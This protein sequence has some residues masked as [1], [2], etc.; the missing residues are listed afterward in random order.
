MKKDYFSLVSAFIVALL[1]CCQL[2]VQAQSCDSLQATTR[3]AYSS[4]GTPLP[5]GILN[6]NSIRP[7]PDG[8]AMI[9]SINIP[10]DKYTGVAGI[11]VPVT[12]IEVGENSVPVALSYQASGIKVQDVASTI[13]LGW[14]LSAGGR[15][16]RAVYGWPDDL[17][18]PVSRAQLLDDASWTVATFRDRLDRCVDTQPDLFY[19]DYPGGGGMFVFDEYGIPS[20]IPGQNLRIEY[21]DRQFV[22]TDINGTEYRF[23]ASEQTNYR[24]GSESDLS[25]K[26]GSFVSTWFL[27]SIRYADGAL[28]TFNYMEASDYCYVN[29]Q[30]FSS[31]DCHH[32]DEDPEIFLP[33]YSSTNDDYIA[34]FTIEIQRPKY[35]SSIRY[36]DRI[37]D[38]SYVSGRQDVPGMLKLSQITTSHA[39]RNIRSYRLAYG[40]FVNKG[41]KLLSLDDVSIEKD[42]R[43]I[44]SFQYHEQINLPARDTCFVKRENVFEAFNY[45]GYTDHWGYY[46]GTKPDSV[47]YKLYNIAKGLF[48]S[49]YKEPS[50]SHAQANTLR[51]ITYGTGGGTKQFE[52]ELHRGVDPSTGV[53]QAAGGLRIRKIVEKAD[54]SAAPSIRSYTY[55]G[56]IVYADTLNYCSGMD[57]NLRI[58]SDSRTEQTGRVFCS[59]KCSNDLTDMN[60]CAVV[61]SAVTEHFPSGARTIYNYVPYDEMPDESPALY[62]VGDRVEY[63]GLDTICMT[64]KTTRHW[65]RRL[66]QRRMDYDANGEMVGSVDYEYARIGRPLKVWSIDYFST[67]TMYKASSDKYIPSYYLSKYYWESQPA[68]LSKV[69]IHKGRHVLASTT[70]YE[71]DETT[72]LPTR[73]VRTDSLGV[74][75]EIEMRYPGNFTLTGVAADHMAQ[76]LAV[77]QERHVLSPFVETVTRRNGRIVDAALNRYT[78]MNDWPMLLERKQLFCEPNAHLTA[79]EHARIDANGQFVSSEEYE[80]V[81]KA[82]GY[83]FDNTLLS[84]S[85]KGGRKSCV[86][87][88]YRNTLPIAVV[89]NA[90]YGHQVVYSGTSEETLHYSAGKNYLSL[91]QS[92][93]VDF[94]VAISP[95][96][97]VGQ[98]L[99]VRIEGRDISTNGLFLQGYYQ[100]VDN[101]IRFTADLRE[102]SY[103][104]Y[105]RWTDAGLAV[106]YPDA[107]TRIRVNDYMP[108]VA[109]VRGYVFHTSFEEEVN[110]P[111]IAPELTPCIFIDNAKSGIRVRRTP[112]EVRLPGQSSNPRDSLELTWWEYHT[113]ATDPQWQMVRRIVPPGNVPMTVVIAA[114]DSVYIDE[115][116]V[117]P[118]DALMTTFTYLPGIGKTSQTD[119]SGVT[120]RYRYDQAGRLTEVLDT[121]GQTVK[122]YTYVGTNQI[123]EETISGSGALQ[124]R[125][126]NLD[127]FGRE[128]IVSE[129]GATP[130]RKDLVQL[131]AYDVMGRADSVVYM[132]YV[133]KGI[134]SNPA[135]DQ[136]AFYRSLLG[137]SMP[138]HAYASMRYDT[139]P[140]GALLASCEPRT[141]ELDEF[142]Y[143]TAFS[144]GFNSNS[145]AVRRYELQTDSVIRWAGYYPAD[146][147]R[148]IE[149]RKARTVSG[150]ESLFR[151]YYDGSDRLV[152]RETM[153]TD[154]H[155]ERTYQVYDDF[156][157]LCYVIPDPGNALFVEN[158]SRTASELN[159]FCYSTFYDRYGRIVRQ[160]KP[161]AGWEEMLY[162]ARDRQ[163]MSRRAGMQKDSTW[164][165][166]RYDAL[167]RPVLTAVHKGGD[168]QTHRTALDAGAVY[169]PALKSAND[170]LTEYHYDDYDWQRDAAHVFAPYTYTRTMNSGGRRVRKT[171]STEQKSCVR[172][173][174]TGRIVKVL[175]VTD[176]VRLATTRFYDVAGRLTQTVSDQYPRQIGTERVI[177]HLNAAGNV[178]AVY[179]EQQGGGDFDATGY[180]KEMEY[181]HC[182][183]LTKVTFLTFID[184]KGAKIRPPAGYMNGWDVLNDKVVLAAY[185]YDELGRI[186]T[187]AIHNGLETSAYS[188][189]LTRPT[190][191]SSP[192]FSYTLAYDKPTT[193]LATSRFDGLLSEVTWSR[194][195]DAPK[196]YVFDYDNFGQLRKARFAENRAGVWT[197]RH[198]FDESADYGPCGTITC[199]GRTVSDGRLAEIEQYYDGFRMTGVE[200]GGQS[201]DDYAYDADGNLT[202]NDLQNVEMHYNLLGLTEKIVDN[203]HEISY[204]YTSEGRK[205]AM[206]VAGSFTYY[207]NTLLYEGGSAVPTQIFH[208]EGFVAFSGTLTTPGEW[209]YKY[210]KT[211]HLG[212]VRALLAVDNETLV[213]EQHADYYP[214]GLVHDRFE[215]LHLNRMLYSGKELQ[216]A[217]IGTNGQLGCYD[218]G[219]RHYDPLTGH[220]MT[221][222]LLAR[223]YSSIS[224]Y[225]FCLNNPILFIDLWGLSPVTRG[226]QGD[227]SDKEPD[228]VDIPEVII[229]PDKHN[230]INSYKWM[231]NGYARLILD[232]LYNL[233]TADNP[234]PREVVKT[235]QDFVFFNRL[236]RHYSKGKGETIVL[237]QEEFEFLVKNGK[238]DLNKIISLENNNYQAPI[239]FYGSTYDLRFSFGTATLYLNDSLLP[240]GF[241]DTYDFDAQ[242]GG[243]SFLNEVITRGYGF[244]VKGQ[245]FDIIYPDSTIKR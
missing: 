71:Y 94:E 55:S 28:I 187:K 47:A 101:R 23:A 224:P 32:I 13:G 216:D 154:T 169:Y 45:S 137:G 85:D 204:I 79:F 18:N 88:G 158:G 197:F 113:R 53:E 214:F 112:Y 72:L 83:D 235:T 213:E 184:H 239:I 178:S 143:T 194:A 200:T 100:P 129:I 56:G 74:G 51:Q 201:Y 191:V 107:E 165:F 190:G 99:E 46:N 222:D 131:Y 164:F 92:Q 15:I 24:V 135:G 29:Y 91:Q 207:R 205:L 226:G 105:Y 95:A 108:L 2:T 171:T 109:G 230:Q 156:G 128:E 183:R 122:R 134:G 168:Y 189:D 120:T 6:G 243:R 215:N 21:E 7:S 221:Q 188:Y 114:S 52:Y 87:Y 69:T 202:R 97:S 217:A 76:T 234:P 58:V 148:R 162:D 138:V 110:T 236:R 132:P 241:R 78:L 84:S 41:L 150:E 68:V 49:L 153:L 10:V 57:V 147:L 35:L 159:K 70:E 244:F 157:R 203:S 192:S 208:P 103:F 36:K 141:G 80:T 59:W 146:A 245:P 86:I 225:A 149:C 50:L 196:A 223:D 25:L 144:Y 104:V 206:C 232:R 82:D 75:T 140:Q 124:M 38:F 14:R 89:Q 90:A 5:K 26:T 61:Y 127:G 182:D 119:P 115:V 125:V 193:G 142:L 48:V 163:I 179:V 180:L 170:I 121:E 133:T 98:E 81:W 238:I 161:G 172:G 218:F 160:S 43:N 145:D 8:C 126:I 63:L 102:G 3:A 93:T 130:L 174:E 139:S 136:A 233:R 228:S 44:C 40:E 177:N 176:D 118:L 27:T 66:L 11:Q 111:A 42:T 181:D 219:A 212:N 155:W 39:G 54:A 34:D 60:G 1:I 198:A 33:P 199:L 77:M 229:R 16:T 237:T 37:V 12:Q 106:S 30:R 185:T 22:L 117:Q 73:I 17:D 242:K 167:D 227:D 152:M 65:L 186:A 67:G 4:D 9:R 62:K 240:V 116:R 173:M 175:G 64:R 151:E 123:E 220:W 166:T 211:D 210:Y 96:G 31:Y 209:T 19:F 20:T 231:N 195:S